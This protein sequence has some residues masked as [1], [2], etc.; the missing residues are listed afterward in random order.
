M[1]GRER[2]GQAARRYVS[3]LQSTSRIIWLV[4]AQG[5]RLSISGGV[6]VPSYL[7]GDI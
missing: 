4:G 3:T 1:K 2:K 5:A 6:C 7:S